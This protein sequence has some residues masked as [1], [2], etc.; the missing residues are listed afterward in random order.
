MRSLTVTLPDDMVEEIE[1]RVANGDY[2]S[3]SDLVRDS[4]EA[5]LGDDFELDEHE[6]A[7]IRASCAEMA[8]DPSLGIPIDEIAERVRRK[9]LSAD[10]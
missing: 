9:A 1:A 10:G 8:A 7:E 2:A 5:H 4:L 3:E 6:I